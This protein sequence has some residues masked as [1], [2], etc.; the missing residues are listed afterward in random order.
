MVPRL[1]DKVYCDVSRDEIERYL[2]AE[3]E[4]DR[5]F[6][7]SVVDENGAEVDLEIRLIFQRNGPRANQLSVAVLLH[8]TRI[9]G[10]DWEGRFQDLNGERK[11]G[12]HRHLWDARV[13]NA[14]QRKIALED[15]GSSFTDVSGFILRVT[16]ELELVLSGKDYGDPQQQ[17]QWA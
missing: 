12:W 2:Y 17:M 15:F 14:E 5:C 13:R 6:T 4:F 10:I 7:V 9:A 11:T 3:G 1:R 8:D 16:E